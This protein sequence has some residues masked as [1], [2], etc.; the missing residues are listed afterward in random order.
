[1]SIR[2]RLLTLA[3]GG[4]VPLLIV[5]LIVLWAVWNGK[6]Q[7]LNEALEQ[8][9]ELAAVVFDRWLDAQYQ[10]LRTIASYSPEHLRD[11]SSL[12]A[13][14]KAARI[15]RPYWIDLRVV[16]PDAKIISK[17]PSDAA[18]LPVG[19]TEKLLAEVQRGVPGC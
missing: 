3:I 12:E 2:G 15:Q 13:D 14:L 4:V 16:D 6:Q 7:Q 11:Q 8:Q 9:A 17:Y 10:P 5:G 19:L 1:M 18:G